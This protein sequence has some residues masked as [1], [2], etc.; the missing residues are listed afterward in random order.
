MGKLCSASLVH[1]QYLA[2]GSSSNAL[3]HAGFK[4]R[5]IQFLRHVT[6]EEFSRERF[7]Q[8]VRGVLASAGQ[9][10]WQAQQFEQDGAWLLLGLSRL[11]ECLVSV[12]RALSRLGIE[13]GGLAFL[14]GTAGVPLL[15]AQIPTL[16]L[17]GNAEGAG[18]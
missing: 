9:V 15:A 11:V 10:P 4:S 12:K 14:R 1:M 6:A 16:V 5:L 18:A 8:L 7:Q 3:G 17:I 13:G 2:L